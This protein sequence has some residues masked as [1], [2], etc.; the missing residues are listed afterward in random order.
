MRRD[1]RTGMFIG[2][3][4]AAAGAVAMLATRDTWQ[5]LPG[6]AIPMV[7]YDNDDGRSRDNAEPAVF[8]AQQPVSG[9]QLSPQKVIDPQAAPV[10]IK[11]IRFH[12]VQQGETLS[13]IAK[14]YYG[15]T[16]AIGKILDA[17]KQTLGNP[18]RIRPGTKITIPD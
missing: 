9:E 3:A 8:S 11:T 12:I 7:N 5:A 13:S 2:L 18:D 1:V 4:L 17:N 10:P 15:T 16:A 6:R 14:R